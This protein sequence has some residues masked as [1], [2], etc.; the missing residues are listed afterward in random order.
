MRRSLG[1]LKLRETMSFLP[2]PFRLID[3]WY[4][5]FPKI[6]PSLNWLCVYK[7]S[8][9]LLFRGRGKDVWWLPKIQSWIHSLQMIK[10]DQGRAFAG[11]QRRVERAEVGTVVSRNFL[12]GSHIWRASSSMPKKAT[13]NFVGQVSN[14]YFT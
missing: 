2:L 13:I 5:R 10:F 14:K 3:I 11:I 12:L 1:F 4:L 8:S 9:A 6:C 7:R